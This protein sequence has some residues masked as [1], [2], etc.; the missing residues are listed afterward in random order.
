[1]KKMIL[2]AMVVCLTAF[3]CGEIPNK[4]EDRVSVITYPDLDTEI[5]SFY[6]IAVFLDCDID[7]VEFHCLTFEGR[8]VVIRTNN[9]DEWCGP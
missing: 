2:A 6:C 1:M 7:T 8:L 3:G 9:M 4:D 5:N